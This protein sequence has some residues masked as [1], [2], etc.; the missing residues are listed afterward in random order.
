[1]SDQKKTDIIGELAF[2]KIIETAM[3]HCPDHLRAVMLVYREGKRDPFIIGNC[4]DNCT[5]VLIH[6]AADITPD[7]RDDLRDTL[8]SKVRH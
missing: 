8:S 4:C 2:V 7:P 6:A 5:N 3:K 1:M